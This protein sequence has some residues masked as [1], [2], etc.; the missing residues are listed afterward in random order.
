VSPWDECLAAASSTQ[1]EV[2]IPGIQRLASMVRRGLE[3]LVDA[4]IA[5][6]DRFLVAER[7]VV[8]GPAIVPVLRPLLRGAQDA[9]TRE[10]AALVMLQLGCHDGVELLV[11]AIR[12][13]SEQSFVA[14]KL[15]AREGVK[16]IIPILTDELLRQ[17]TLLHS[18]DPPG[19][20]VYV[21]ALETLG[22]PIPAPF[23]EAASSESAPWELRARV[24]RFRGPSS[25]GPG[26]SSL[27]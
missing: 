6:P 22:A 16:S 19:L 5:G 23:L 8:V 21:Q 11:D 20:E 3:V 12:Q 15:L 9:E 26:T 13:R 18:C 2:R 14:I 27:S 24:E 17:V 7:L 10:L 25:R 4:L 1:I